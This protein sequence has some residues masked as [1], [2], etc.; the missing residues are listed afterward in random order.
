MK[1]ESTQGGVRGVTFEDVLLS[2]YASDGGLFMPECTP[3]V[4]L[5]T[6]QSWVGLGYTD[7]AKK[8]V[9][10]FI[11]ETEI[12]TV[13]LE[14]EATQGDQ[15]IKSIFNIILLG[16]VP[17]IATFS[18]HIGTC[19]RKCCFFHFSDNLLPYTLRT[20]QLRT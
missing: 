12:S 16:F 15:I 13:E 2:G 1:Y 11:D 20:V 4:D 5:S 17:E 14:G 9:R 10:L 3:V 6:L 19:A 7:L 18:L 8:L